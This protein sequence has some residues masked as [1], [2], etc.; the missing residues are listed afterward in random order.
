[1]TFAD[2]DAL[3]RQD[4]QA[5]TATQESGQPLV[6]DAGAGGAGQL[7]ASTLER[8]NVDIA[9]EF[10]KLIVAQRAY[11]ANTRVISASDEMLAETLQMRR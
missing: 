11:S 6:Q 3:A 9:S 2:P 5:F 1:V 7:L 8:S 4:G 10:T